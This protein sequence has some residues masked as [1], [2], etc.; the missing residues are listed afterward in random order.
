MFGDEL[1]IVRLILS[2]TKRHILM[3][4][5]RDKYFF[6][7]SNGFVST[8]KSFKFFDWGDVVSG[9]D[10]II[11]ST[12]DAITLTMSLIAFASMASG[13]FFSSMIL[14]PLS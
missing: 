4:D 5:S 1:S 6:S 14:I 2:Y 10:L 7:V 11:S 9:L 13:V 12:A 3:I 8:I